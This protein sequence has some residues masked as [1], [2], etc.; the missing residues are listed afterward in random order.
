MEPHIL[1]P[2]LVQ[3]LF[4]FAH[5]AHTNHNVRGEDHIIRRGI[6]PYII[7]PM[8]AASTL[9][10]DP[11]ISIEER[12][13]GFQILMLHDILEDTSASLPAWVS[14]EVQDGVR[15]LSHESWEQELIDI[16]SYTPFFKLLK[17]CDKIQTLYERGV[18]LPEKRPRWKQLVQELARDVE[19]QYGTTR[20]G[21]IANAL[22]EH[23]DW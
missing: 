3:Q 21:T 12:I 23:T 10:M 7:H 6:Y 8:W 9:I 20:V 5:D 13:L 17:L 4:E 1:D 2:K 11:D 22:V 14:Q 16:A 15:R 18:V 19:A